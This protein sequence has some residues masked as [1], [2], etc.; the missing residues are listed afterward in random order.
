MT[1]AIPAA[2]LCLTLNVYHEAGSEPQKGKSAVAHVTLNRA[3]NK[4]E[5]ICKVVYEKDQ[6]SWTKTRAN[7]RKSKTR[8]EYAINSQSEAWQSSLYAAKE[9]MNNLSVDPTNGAEFF[10]ASYVKPKWSK[11]LEKTAKIGNHVFY[12]KLDYQIS[13][14]QQ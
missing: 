4:K 11:K 1:N 3:K 9:A 7:L 13:Y 14:N 5:K 2:L 6:F 10:H 8:G 12:R